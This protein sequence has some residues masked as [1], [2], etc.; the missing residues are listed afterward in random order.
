MMKPG[1]PVHPSNGTGTAPDAAT[2]PGG[3]E[4][5]FDEGPNSAA[6]GSTLQVVVTNREAA[7]NLEIS[8]AGGRDGL[9]F[10]VAPNTT[11]PFYVSIFRM[12]VRGASGGTA[13]YSILGIV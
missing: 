7:Q 2:T 9:W 11:L 3:T 8:F 12:Y 4:V 6:R 5:S 10:A 1:K 13:D